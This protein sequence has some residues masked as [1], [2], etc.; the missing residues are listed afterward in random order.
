MGEVV[1]HA[2]NGS[3]EARGG[4]ADAKRKRLPEVSNVDYELIQEAD[5]TGRDAWSR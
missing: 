4:S 1:N 5:R 2:N 3:F